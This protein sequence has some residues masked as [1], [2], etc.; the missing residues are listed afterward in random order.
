MPRSD[1][2]SQNENGQGDRK[3]HRVSIATVTMLVS[4]AK[5]RPDFIE[6]LHA[7]D[8]DKEEKNNFETG[9]EERV[10][11]DCKFCKMKFRHYATAK[12]HEKYVHLQLRLYS[13]SYCKKKFKRNQHV[14]RHEENACQ[15]RQKS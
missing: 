2:D 12:N 13:C 8:E 7:R 10:L 6:E 15:M 4:K 3:K 1:S 11:F 9:T 14:K 5:R